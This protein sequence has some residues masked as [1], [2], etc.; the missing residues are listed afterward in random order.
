MI[1]HETIPVSVLIPTKN[2]EKNIAECLQSVLWASEIIVF[3]SFS[4]DKTLE[5]ARQMGAKIV[6]REFDNFSA[7]KNWAIDNIDFKHEWILIVDADE[8]ITEE[9]TKEIKTLFQNNLKLNGYYIARQNWFAGKW[10]RHGGWYPDWHCR[11]LRIGYARYE[12]RIVHEHILLEGQ[13]G[14]LKNPLIHYDYKGIERYFDR[15]NTYSSMEAVEIYRTLQLPAT[16]SNQLIPSLFSKSP[17]RRRFLKNIAYRY[18]PARPLFKFFWMYIFK[19]GFLDGFIG[20]R[21]CLLHTFYDYQ[22]SLK[23]EELKNPKSPLYQ[24]YETFL[25]ETTDKES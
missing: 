3:D 17:A 9:L 18:L 19:L 16:Q 21:Y 4:D 8:R 6:Q 10:I 24:K 13:A 22:I 23:L 7:H 5:I 20:F 15:H 2:E 11:L 1:N 12:S 25:V 14:F